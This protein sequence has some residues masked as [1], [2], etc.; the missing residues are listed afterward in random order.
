MKRRL[1]C[2][3]NQKNAQDQVDTAD[4]LQ[5]VEGGEEEPC[6]PCHPRLSKMMATKDVPFDA[7]RMMYGGF[8]VLVEM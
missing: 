8:K 6:G 5:I 3:G 1:P 4:H 7:K 2:S